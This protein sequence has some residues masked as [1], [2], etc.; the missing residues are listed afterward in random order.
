MKDP[1]SA[2]AGAFRA[3]GA[4]MEILGARKNIRTLMIVNAEPADART[5]IAANVAV[6][7]ALQ[8]KQVILL[9]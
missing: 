2:E 4:R 8:G 3:L 1:H 5:T 7:N 6:V 9:D